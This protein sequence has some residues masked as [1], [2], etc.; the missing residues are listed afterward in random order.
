[1]DENGLRSIS[2]LEKL[3]KLSIISAQNNR[4][5]EISDIEKLLENSEL[6]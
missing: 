4:F 1:M 3:K 6:V 2:N 5:Q